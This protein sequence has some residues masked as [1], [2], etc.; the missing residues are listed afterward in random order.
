MFGEGEA[1][2]CCP[3]LYGRLQE[4]DPSALD[5]SVVSQYIVLSM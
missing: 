1:E 5:P 4:D 2:R 3:M